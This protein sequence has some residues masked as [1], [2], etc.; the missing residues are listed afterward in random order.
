MGKKFFSVWSNFWNDGRGGSL[1]GF[2]TALAALSILAAVPCASAQLPDLDIELV[3]ENLIQISWDDEGGDYKLEM[4]HDLQIWLSIPELLP[5]PLLGTYRVPVT[6][7]PD[8]G[9]FRVLGTFPSLYVSNTGDDFT[10]YAR[11]QKIGGNVPPTTQLERGNTTRLFQPRAVAVTRTGRL[12]ISRNNG[13]IVGWNDARF[14]TGAAPADIEVDGP[15]TGLDSPIAFA[16]DSNFDRLFVGNTD[17]QDGILVFDL[18]SAPLLF[19]GD[20]SPSRAFGPD[21]RRPFNSNPTSLLMTID[22]LVLDGNTLYAADASGANV[23]SSRIL[24]FDNAATANGQ[25]NPVRTITGPWDEV[26][27]L[28]IDGDNLYL[29]D[30]TDVLFV[31]ED[32][33]SASG[34][35]TPKEV[36]VTVTGATLIQLR[37]VEIFNGQTYMLDQNN[38]SILAFEG[39]FDGDEGTVSPNRKIEG[40]NTGLRRPTS[41][42]VGVSELQEP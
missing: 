15:S 4:S 3:N 38:S 20:V 12:L 1:R 23:N 28:A 6:T 21:D 5:P 22:A 32:Y 14:A 2:A 31:I 8:R 10:S 17:T 9:F 27:S 42:A 7:A 34:A 18:V 24:V 40:S 29:V 39:T 16:Y 25:T 11:F 37:T 26:R 35:V 19:D 13:G 33:D 41:M 30:D 36:T